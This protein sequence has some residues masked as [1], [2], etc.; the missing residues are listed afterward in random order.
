[1]RWVNE[2]SKITND[3]KYVTVC[4][5]ND[6]EFELFN[7]KKYNKIYS[8]EDV[9]VIYRKL[10]ELKIPEKK[11]KLDVDIEG[12]ITSAPRFVTGLKCLPDLVKVDRE[13]KVTES[14]WLTLFRV[15]VKLLDLVNW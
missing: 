2:K 10:Q 9:D 7:S 13:M 5:Y 15:V 12:L 3:F 14:T 1:M 11:Y 4:N 8:E 6:V